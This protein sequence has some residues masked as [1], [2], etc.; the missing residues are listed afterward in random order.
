MNA[1]GVDGLIEGGRVDRPRALEIY[2]YKVT[3]RHSGAELEIISADSHG[4]YGHLLDFLLVDELA[5]WRPTSQDFWTALISTAGKRRHCM[6]VVITNAGWLSSWTYKVREAVCG[7]PNWY[8]RSLRGSIASWI[9]EGQLSEQRRLLPPQQYSRLWDN[10][11]SSDS[12]DWISQAD[13]EA[14]L[15][16]PGPVPPNTD[17]VDW[18]F[19]CVDLGFKR[20]HS[21]L[22]TCGMSVADQRLVVMNVQSWS[23]EQYGG[24]VDATA[25]AEGIFQ[26]FFR[27]RLSYVLCDYHQAEV[28][29]QQLCNRGVRIGCVN[30][31]AKESDL[32]ARTML[33]GFQDRRLALYPHEGLLRDLHKVR[34]VERP[35]GLKLDPP[36]D[37]DGHGD[38]AMALA[39][40]C[41]AEGLPRPIAAY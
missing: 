12:G 10:V 28:L 16:L 25:V 26:E 20:H 4:A 2:Q 19:A 5:N 36:Q 11:W 6:T 34:I 13:I 24:R 27:Y 22:V 30:I 38:R 33:R 32:M 3:N 23:P 1:E 41:A 21:A 39:M 17:L 7:D 18:S 35:Y 40:C 29:A 31:S 37:T 8:V 14:C 15:T 9:S